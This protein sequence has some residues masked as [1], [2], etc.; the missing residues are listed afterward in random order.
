MPYP[1]PCFTGSTGNFDLDLQILG[2]YILGTAQRFD[3]HLVP[4]FCLVMSKCSE[5]Q[6]TF[7]T[8]TVSLRRFPSCSLQ[9]AL[10]L[11]FL[12]A[13]TLLSDFGVG[14]CCLIVFLPTEIAGIIFGQQDNTA[15]LNL[16]RI[17]WYWN[18][19]IFFLFSFFVIL[20]NKSY[21]KFPWIWIFFVK[22][23]MQNTGFCC[24]SL[25]FPYLISLQ[26]EISFEFCSLEKGSFS[27][28]KTQ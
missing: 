9:G 21:K 23:Y 27:P 7:L 19:C 13:R 6:S 16:S 3:W 24:R 2:S 20:N 4:A 26:Q 1:C 12:F 17:F 10:Q 5:F 28:L 14:T 8:D 18:L 25:M 15:G 22:C 11:R